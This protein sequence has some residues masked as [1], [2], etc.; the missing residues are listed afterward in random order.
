MNKH[1]IIAKLTEVAVKLNYSLTCDLDRYNQ[2]FD[3][4]NKDNIINFYIFLIDKNKQYTSLEKGDATHFA[5]KYYPQGY[6]KNKYRLWRSDTLV[7][8]NVSINKSV[9]QIVKEIQTRFLT[10]QFYDNWNRLIK[11]IEYYNKKEDYI[12]Q[13]YKSITNNEL[14][15]VNVN[16]IKFNHYLDKSNYNKNIGFDIVG[17]DRIDLKLNCL[18]LEQALKV[19]ELYESFNIINN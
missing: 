17:I 11:D 16:N 18:N 8:I 19:K 2:S 9:D 13:V 1:E 12:Q 5:V 14:K 7:D 3:F 10:S 15:E 4:T 6:T